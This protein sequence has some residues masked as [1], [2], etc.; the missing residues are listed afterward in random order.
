MDNHECIIG[1]LNGYDCYD[2]SVLVTLYE[3]K[4]HIQKN[5]EWNERLE[6]DPSLRNISHLYKKRLSMRDYADKRKLTDLT[7]FDYCPVCGKK[8]NWADIRRTCDD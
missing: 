4:K 1:I 8:I 7:R 5:I 6:E 2:C 3:L